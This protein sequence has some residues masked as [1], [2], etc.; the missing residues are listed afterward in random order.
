MHTPTRPHRTD[1][2]AQGFESL[3][4][5]V[6]AAVEA[7]R[8]DAARLIAPEASKPALWEQRQASI[9]SASRLG[10]E[11]RIALLTSAGQDP[12]LDEALARGEVLFDQWK[13]AA[14]GEVSG[15]RGSVRGIDPQSL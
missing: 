10:P 14:N 1:K 11:R 13:A 3:L 6:R 7:L 4:S 9:D 15:A 2:A 5:T 8:L 12:G